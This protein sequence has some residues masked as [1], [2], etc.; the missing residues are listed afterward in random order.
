M[1]FPVKTGAPASQRTECAILPIF[2]DG[3]LRGATKDLDTAARGLIKQLVRNGDA[4][5]RLGSAALIHRTQGT[6]AARWLLA[7]CG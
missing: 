2:D 4:S 6:A 3:Q 1:E 7:G 5:P